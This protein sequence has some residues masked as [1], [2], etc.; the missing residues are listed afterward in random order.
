MYF[1]IYVVL[2]IGILFALNLFR[3]HLGRAFIAI[4]DRDIAACFPG[5]V[6]VVATCIIDG[7]RNGC[8]DRGEMDL[9]DRRCGRRLSLERREK[10]IDGRPEFGLDNGPGLVAGEGRQARH[11]HPR[12]R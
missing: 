9:S 7:V 8:A 2:A 1:L 10:R 3:T 5:L 4:R 12:A 11:H 6:R